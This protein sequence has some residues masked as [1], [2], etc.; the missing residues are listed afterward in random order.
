MKPLQA[1]INVSFSLTLLCISK[2]LDDINLEAIIKRVYW[3]LVPFKGHNL[4]LR[5]LCYCFKLESPGN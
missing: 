3:A 5:N 4:L 2:P 1:F